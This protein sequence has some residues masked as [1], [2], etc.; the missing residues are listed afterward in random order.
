MTIRFPHLDVSPSSLLFHNLTTFPSAHDAATPT[1]NTLRVLPPRASLFKTVFDSLPDAFS[2]LRPRAFRRSQEGLI[3]PPS[4]TPLSPI[5]ASPTRALN[6]SPLS[7]SVVEGI[8]YPP[9]PHSAP[10]KNFQLS[11][12]PKRSAKLPVRAAGVVGGEGLGL[13]RASSSS[14]DDA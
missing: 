3:A 6:N 9:S 8:V 14:L 2:Q 10:P 7:P 5:P 4:Q 11:A 13:R 12:P 1:L